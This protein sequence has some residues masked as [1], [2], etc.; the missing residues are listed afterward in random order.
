MTLLRLRTDAKLFN[1]RE[2]IHR[3]YHGAVESGVHLM[4]YSRIEFVH[5]KPEKII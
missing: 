3:V 4:K 5:T 2:H 1:V